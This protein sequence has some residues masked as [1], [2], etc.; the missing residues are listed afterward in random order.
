MWGTMSMF[1]PGSP[2]FGRFSDLCKSRRLEVLRAAGG[3]PL[4]GQRPHIRVR[5][6]ASGD[7]G[8]TPWILSQGLCAETGLASHRVQGFGLPKPNTKAG[9][10]SCLATIFETGSTGLVPRER[11]P[12]GR[13]F[14]EFQLIT[15]MLSW[16]EKI[17]LLSS[18]A[19]SIPQ[20]VR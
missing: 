17:R 13:R 12:A 8:W 10:L 3:D 7:P 16:A 15:S 18:Q 2:P 5:L 20:F 9:A 19:A 4:Q 14:R 6:G 1:K 11:K